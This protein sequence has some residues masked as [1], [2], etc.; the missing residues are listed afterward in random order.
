MNEQQLNS[1]Q[2]RAVDCIEGAVLVLAG[3]GSG[4]TKVLTYRIANM[5][6][7]GISPYE[8]LAITFTNKASNE[9]KAR[10]NDMVG[11]KGLTV[12]TIHSL[13]VRILRNEA[14]LL[15][16]HSN[17][18]IYD[19][20]DTAT[21][22]K[23]IFS[24]K[25][26]DDDKLKKEIVNNINMAKTYNLTVEEASEIVTTDS[27]LFAYVYEKYLQQLKKSN[28]FDFDGLLNNC[29]YLFENFPQTLEKYQ[30][31][32]KY[33]SIDEFQDTNKVQ[34]N[35]IKLLSKKYG[36]LFVV[37]DDDQSIYGWRGAEID[38]ILNFNQDFPSANVFT[39]EQNYRST[40]KI[41]QVANEIISKN[42]QR[43]KKEL[44]TE[45]EAGV[46]VEQFSANEEG[47]EAR[48][49]VEQ[50]LAL[51]RFNKYNYSDFAILMRVNALSRNFEQECLKYNL[52]FKVFGGFKFFDRKE[53]KDLLAYLKIVNNI[54]DNSALL[55]IINTPKRGI[56]LAT[57]NKVTQQAN[58]YGISILQFLA[59]ERNLEFLGSTT[60]HKLV[61][62]Y[63]LYEDLVKLQQ[64][65]SLLDFVKKAISR[66]QYK[67]TLTQSEEDAERALNI[68]ELISSV[69]QFCQENGQEAT[70]AEYLQSVSIMA[71]NGE[72]DQDNF[73]T[74]STIHSAKGLEFKV[75][76]VVGL[77]NG[78]FPLSRASYSNKEMQEER[79]LAYVAV[80]R[81]K[82]RLYLTRSQSRFVY[83][84]RSFCSA[85]PFYKE[86]SDLITPPPTPSYDNEGV[87]TYTP[88]T[89]QVTPKLNIDPSIYTVS[90]VV[91]HSTFGKGIILSID[92]GN[93]IVAFDTVGKKNL[94][95]K[96]APLTKA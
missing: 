53:I 29:L 75:V 70:L 62:F 95:L 12:C 45:H 76:F 87:P 66:T 94:S 59:D 34:Y 39:L 36:N 35:I 54:Y 27:E 84:S 56:G 25:N 21:L 17:F 13:A 78:I 51:I 23:S 31:R 89:R 60:S 90:E 3:A 86:V 47:Q 92:S 19:E 65:N 15:G 44:F 73:V 32:F 71:D 26:I 64:N 4:K 52:P 24:Q 88:R 85:S 93:A 83:G 40:K 5:I 82:E 81:A 48:Y 18:S 16:Y 43:H 55:R 96:Y 80:T 20:Q 74:I 46:K 33:I 50:M 8:I 9:M 22:L 91:V 63:A 41:L 11:S 37:G 6:A 69:E 72:V 7:R 38:N 42:E 68:D 58:S 2:Q 28:A 10:L 79:R 30:E 67:Q 77:D 61:D 49:V 14:E 57:I 1:A